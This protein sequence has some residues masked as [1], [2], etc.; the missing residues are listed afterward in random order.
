MK[1]TFFQKHFPEYA[2]APVSMKVLTWLTVLQSL[3]WLIILLW[4]AW[5]PLPVMWYSAV[6][7]CAVAALTAWTAWRLLCKP[8]SGL[9]WALLTYFTALIHFHTA[10]GWFWDATGLLKLS[11]GWGSFDGGEFNIN[12]AAL[13]LWIL[14][15]KNILFFK[16]QAHAANPDIPKEQI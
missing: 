6:I 8:I 9:R 15:A 16:E 7:V 10:S 1:L 11:F 14:A 2:T 12:I 4:L 3:Y 5:Q 13:V